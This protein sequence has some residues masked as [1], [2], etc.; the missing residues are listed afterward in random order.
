[1]LRSNAHGNV[2]DVS[3][4]H[5]INLTMVRYQNRPSAEKNVGQVPYPLRI[6]PHR[7]VSTHDAYVCI[8]FAVCRIFRYLLILYISCSI[9]CTFVLHCST[10]TTI[11]YIRNSRTSHI[12]LPHKLYPPI[13]S[14]LYKHHLTYGH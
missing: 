6:L 3:P 4:V 8:P 14:R 2:T 7:N 1:M 10:I 5:A 13:S 11:D 9:I 12:R